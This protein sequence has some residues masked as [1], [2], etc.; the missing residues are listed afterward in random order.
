MTGHACEQTGT[1]PAK[2]DLLYH[3]RENVH[4]YISFLFPEQ[5]VGGE[6]VLVY[7][8]SFNLHSNKIYE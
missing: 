4:V 5:G 3:R 8:K 1:V 7:L 2:Q 6:E